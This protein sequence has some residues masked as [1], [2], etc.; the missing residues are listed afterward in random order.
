MAPIAGARDLVARRAQPRAAASASRAK[1]A[2]ATRAR[3]QPLPSDRPARRGR[4]LAERAQRAARTPARFARHAALL[5]R[6]CRARAALAADRAEAAAAAAATRRRRGGTR[7]RRSRRSPPASSARRAWSSSCWRSRAAS[8]ARRAPRS[9]RSISA[10]W[11]ARRSPPCAPFAHDRGSELE[12]DAE[13]A[14][15]VHGERNALAVLVRNLVDN[16]VRYSP[17]GRSWRCGSQR[18]WTVRWCCRSTTTARASPTPIASACSTVSTGVPKRGASP[19]AGS[20]WRSC[21]GRAAPRRAI[22]ARPVGRAVG[23][24]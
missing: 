24:A 10:S 11:R 14:A 21:A 19:A 6:R 16:A 4:S 1:C 17:A 15:V 20:A 18:R 9:S 8:P 7:A 13:P 12:L 2:R 3:S 5:R 22:D 23:C